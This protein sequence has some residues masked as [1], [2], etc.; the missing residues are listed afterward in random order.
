MA[1]FLTPYL[2]MGHYRCSTPS[3]VRVITLPVEQNATD[4]P[5]R[6]GT[7]SLT[8]VPMGPSAC[9]MSSQTGYDNEFHAFRLYFLRFPSIVIIV[10]IA[11]IGSASSRK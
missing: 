9:Q 10:V 3:S 6:E 4:V 5:S 2:T 7:M 1:H 8:W 11:Y